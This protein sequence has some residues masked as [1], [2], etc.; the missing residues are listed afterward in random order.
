L[1]RQ[2]KY[3]T[4]ILALLVVA[5]CTYGCQNSAPAS[6]LWEFSKN[7]VSTKIELRESP[8][9]QLELL[10]TFTP[11]LEHFH[12]YSKDLPRNGLNGL[13][14]PTLLEVVSPSGAI[15]LKGAL[16]AY[17]TPHDLYFKILDLSF[18]V[19]P[20]GAVMLGLPFEFI[21]TADAD[22]VEL[23]VTYMACSDQTCL[24]PVV[25]KHITINIPHP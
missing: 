6:A 1:I 22:S 15:R 9:G 11:T 18:P 4:T 19:Y 7:G 5:S 16:K 25:D 24:A 20:E 3:F 21:G 8:S 17:Q 13:G 12:L 14:R 23:S 2:A 10:G